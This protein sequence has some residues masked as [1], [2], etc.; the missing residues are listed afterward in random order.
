MRLHSACW[1]TVGLFCTYIFGYVCTKFAIVG[2]RDEMCSDFALQST[3]H[4]LYP[5]SECTAFLETDASCANGVVFLHLLE[6]AQFLYV[7]HCVT[8]SSEYLRSYGQQ[9][10]SSCWWRPRPFCHHGYSLAAG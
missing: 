6:T 8:L 4:G 3:C 1:S 10:H 9:L 2:H 7:R 5:S